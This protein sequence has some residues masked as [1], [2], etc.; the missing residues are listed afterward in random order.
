MAETG[1]LTAPAAPL[2]APVTLV[3]VAII[4][5][6]LV[7][8][9]AVAASG[10]LFRDV[11]PS[12]AVI[13]RALVELLMDK[14]YY[15]HLG[16]TAGEIGTALLIG[17]L[18]G[19]AVGILLGSNRFLS[20][21]YEAFLYYLG[22]TPKIIFF[23]VMIMWF[24]VGPGSKVAM[25]TIS[26]FFP[27]A[28]SAAAGMRQI[29]PILIRVGRSFRASTWQMVTKIYLPA[30]RMPILNGVRLGLGVAI[31]GTLL[32]ETKLSNRGIGFLIINAYSTFNMPRMY[33]LLIVLFVLSIGVNALVG[34]LGGVDA[35]KR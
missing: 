9:E 13:G 19:L 16:V 18:S 2:L 24:G 23:P 25:G 28:L 1:R 33:A 14:T 8:W 10:L 26:C 27:V 3:R 5:A 12:L 34:R 22:P 30:M 20:S 31:I 4:A 32:A 7:T 15:W 29:N 17:G 11:V 21:A 6:V 35:I